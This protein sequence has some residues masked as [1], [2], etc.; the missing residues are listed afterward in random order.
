MMEASENKSEKAYLSR[1]EAAQY[2]GVCIRVFDQMKA[3][4]DIPYSRLTGRRLLF[5]RKDLDAIMRERRID[6]DEA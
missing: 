5:A 3:R 2:L 1:K 4:G 6:I